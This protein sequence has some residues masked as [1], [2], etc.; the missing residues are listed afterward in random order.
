MA[1]LAKNLSW[2]QQIDRAVVDNTGLNGTCDI[3]HA[4]FAPSAQ[5]NADATATESSLPATIF[6]ALREELGLKLESTKGPVNVFFI[7]HVERL[8]PN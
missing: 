3:E 4:P 7:D 1:V 8:S 5:V 6:D 2:S